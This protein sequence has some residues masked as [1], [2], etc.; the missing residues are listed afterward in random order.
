MSPPRQA[1]LLDPRAGWQTG[2]TVNVASPGQQGI[3][4]ARTAPAAA[5]P[6]WLA[7]PYLLGR[8]GWVRRYDQLTTHITPILCAADYGVT[9]ENAAL[10]ASGEDLYLLSPDPPRLLVFSVLGYPRDVLHRDA[11]AIWARIAAENTVLPPGVSVDA[12]GN[13]QFPGLPRRVDRDGRPACAPPDTALTRPDLDTRGNWISDQLDSHLYRCDWHRVRLAARLPRA[14]ASPSARTARTSPPPPPR[15]PRWTRAR[16]AVR[17]GPRWR[18]RPADPQRQRPIS[19]G[20][21]RPVRRRVQLAVGHQHPAGVPAQLLPAL[22][23]RR[24]LRRPGQRRLPGPLPGDRADLRRGHRGRARRDARPL[25]SQGSAR[26][27]RRLPGRLAERGGR[28]HLD[29]GAAAAPHRRRQGLPP[30]PGHPGG[31]PA[32]RRRLPDQH[33]RRYP[34]RRRPAAARR[35]LPAAP[36]PH[37]ALQRERPAPAVEPGRDGQGEA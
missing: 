36:L 2:S 27:V 9:S 35:G 1:I 7:V 15:S 20:P 12:R 21:A 17:P 11:E 8:D 22:P 5:L 4:L 32:A 34:A 31:H 37:A 33:V 13:V 29:P 18:Q 26:P 28:G 30:P 24:L 25:R 3:E 16:G 14:T 19:L 10:T 6:R 23:A